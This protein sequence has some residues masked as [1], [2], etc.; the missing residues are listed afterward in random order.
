M[1]V[2]RDAQDRTDVQIAVEDRQT[3]LATVTLSALT[4]ARAQVGRYASGIRTAPTTVAITDHTRARVVV[5][6][7]KIDQNLDTQLA[8]QV[9][10]GAANV[11]SCD[12]LDVTVERGTS[13]PNSRT[14][15]RI[16]QAER[17]LQVASAEPG[18]SALEITVNGRRSLVVELRGHND[19][20]R[21]VDL[22]RGLLPGTANVVQVTP[23]GPPGA[24]A[25]LLLTSQPSIDAGEHR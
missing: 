15:T 7:T 6:A 13:K 4:N 12:A 11:T 9:G 21:Q 17:Y 24:T 20:V 23:I 5:T 1:D 8:L 16:G 14:F 2:D 3:G 19:D 18:P 10:D 25:W 22:S